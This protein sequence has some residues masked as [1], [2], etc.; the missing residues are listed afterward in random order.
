MDKKVGFL[1][2]ITP[3]GHIWFWKA[4]K[5]GQEGHPDYASWQFSQTDNPYIDPAETEAV[6]DELPE[7]L[8]RQEILAEFLAGGASIFGQGLVTE[9]AIM[10]YLATPMGD[11]YVGVDLADKE[12]FTVIDAVR[13][14][15]HRPCYHDRFNQLG[16]PTQKEQIADAIKSIQAE[17]SVTSVTVVLDSTGIGD[18]VYEDLMA[19]GVDCIPQKFSNDWKEKAV[20]LLAA[21][22]ERGR[23]HIY[24]EQTGEF[25][26]Y[27][28]SMTDAGKYKFEAAGGGHD[29][30]VS[31]K[32]LQHWGLKHMGPPEISEITPAEEEA[33]KV[34]TGLPSSSADD[35]V[36]P[37]TPA[38]IMNNPDA[39]N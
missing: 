18:V 16:W 6:K 29:D 34:D 37:D 3:G 24:E 38:Q 4:W 12:D 32:L 39:W 5:K 7:I 14:S 10:D 19:M 2:I 1:L 35:G 25:E 20:K 36:K 22:L 11:V 13:E 26:G 21:D 33:A 28:F 15:D 9:G 30:E 31:A 8:Y 17:P 23:A 27:E